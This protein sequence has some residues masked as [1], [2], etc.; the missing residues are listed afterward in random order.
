MIVYGAEQ[1]RISWEFVGNDAC[2]LRLWYNSRA[3][4]TSEWPAF[5]LCIATKLFLIDK[6]QWEALV[7]FIY[8]RILSVKY[9]INVTLPDILPIYCQRTFQCSGMSS[10]FINCIRFHFVYSDVILM[11]SQKRSHISFDLRKE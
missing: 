9:A 8:L 1:C 4:E 10:V 11:C 7:E 6:L 3:K 5:F 2:L